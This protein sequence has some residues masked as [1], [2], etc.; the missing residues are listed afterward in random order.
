[1]ASR[2]A[3]EELSSRRSGVYRWPTHAQQAPDTELVTLTLQPAVIAQVVPRATLIGAYLATG[4]ANLG[5]VEMAVASG[6]CIDGSVEANAEGRQGFPR[7]RRT[8]FSSI[9]MLGKRLFQLS[10]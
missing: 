7:R 8:L 4:A 10:D 6:T 9:P 5:G 3:R 2:E 1:M